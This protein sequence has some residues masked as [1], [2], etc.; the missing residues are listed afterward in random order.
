MTEVRR[1]YN[2]TPWEENKDSN[3]E[4]LTRIPIPEE[5]SAHKQENETTTPGM[6]ER[7][8]WLRQKSQNKDCRI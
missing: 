2:L 6:E 5:E 3:A 7:Y 8:T 1:Q 4:G